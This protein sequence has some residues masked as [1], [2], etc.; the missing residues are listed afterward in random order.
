MISKE[1]KLRTD[2]RRNRPSS[3]TRRISTH[4]RN[5]VS[6][7]RRRRLMLPLHHSPGHHRLRRSDAL[8]RRSPDCQRRLQG[9]PLRGGG[10][11]AGAG[12]RRLP[13]LEQRTQSGG[14]GGF[15]CFAFRV[16]VGTLC[17]FTHKF[18]LQMYDKQTRRG[19]KGALLVGH[20]LGFKFWSEDVY[21]T[22]PG[23]I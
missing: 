3:L 21:E 9:P 16:V 13:I 17:G 6:V 14:L 4:L 19:G 15:F 18:K 8:H 12:A 2:R 10:K 23:T 22:S 20:G 5:V 11:G 1:I 7:V